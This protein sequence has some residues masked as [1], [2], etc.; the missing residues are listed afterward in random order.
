MHSPWC[1]DLVARLEY[2]KTF[3]ETASFDAHF[4]QFCEDEK[5]HDL[6]CTP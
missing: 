2:E 6:T 3:A 4:G 5:V 1:K